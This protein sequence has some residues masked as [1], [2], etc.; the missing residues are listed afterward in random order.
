MPL[1]VQYGGTGATNADDA[2]KNL[3]IR[4]CK[5]NLLDNSDFTNPVNQRGQS[6]YSFDSGY[7][8]DRWKLHWT[9]DGSLCINDGYI[10]L[11]RIEHSAYLFQNIPMEMGIMG[12][13]VTVAAKVRGEG[14]VGF[15]FNDGAIREST[16]FDS[17][18]WQ[19]VTKTITV[20]YYSYSNTTLNGVELSTHLDSTVDVEWAALYEGEYTAETLPPY[21][22]KGYGAELAECQRYYQKVTGGLGAGVSTTSGSVLVFV[23]LPVSMRLAE[24]T[25]T[26]VNSLWAY[27]HTGNAY[28]LTY[29]SCLANQNGI[30]LDCTSNGSTNYPVNVPDINIEIFADL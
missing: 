26:F 27:T 19:I 9:G 14:V 24:P 4:E 22:P 8:I 6:D 13:I 21:V 2:R 25:V 1:E 29:K 30:R 17:D 11:A 16:S 28:S 3:G 15:C 7:T 12:K 18:E 5:R 23:P 10:S 20:P